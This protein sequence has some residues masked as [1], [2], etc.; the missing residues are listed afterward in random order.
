MKALRVPPAPAL[1]LEELAVNV[2]RNFFCK[3]VARSVLMVLAIL[4][5]HLQSWEFTT[6]LGWILSVALTHRIC[7][8]GEEMTDVN[9]SV[10]DVLVPFQT[11]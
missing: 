7:M 8:I 3:K 11:I 9:E 6:H 4:R 5:V 1:S 10:I 2:L